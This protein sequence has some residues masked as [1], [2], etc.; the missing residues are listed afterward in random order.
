MSAIFW[1]ARQIINQARPCSAQGKIN[2]T[3]IISPFDPFPKRPF[4]K[5]T[6]LQ[7]TLSQVMSFGA[8]SGKTEKELRK[9]ADRVLEKLDAEEEVADVLSWVR[10]ELN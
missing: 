2:T 4:P 8:G 5:R 3:I 6:L 9:W 10:A 1:A 7:T